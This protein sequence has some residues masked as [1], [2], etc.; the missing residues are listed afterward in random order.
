MLFLTHRWQFSLIDFFMSLFLRRRKK[1]SFYVKQPKV[2]FRPDVIYPDYS[3]CAKRAERGGWMQWFKH[4]P[5]FSNKGTLIYCVRDSSGR[6][7]CEVPLYRTS[8]S[9]DLLFLLSLKINWSI[10][11]L[12]VVT[13]NHFLK[14]R[15]ATLLKE[16]SVWFLLWKHNQCRKFIWTLNA[17]L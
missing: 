16:K 11:Q 9:R 3:L 13:W 5:G 15:D 8:A 7:I 12:W 10:R 2:W 4:A 14:A 6:N 17:V 1:P